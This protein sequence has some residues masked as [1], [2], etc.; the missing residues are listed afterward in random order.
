MM[1]AG[2][3]IK[4]N[5]IIFTKQTVHL[6]ARNN[7]LVNLQKHFIH[8]LWNGSWK[9]EKQQRNVI[10]I[11]LIFPSRWYIYG[12][13]CCCSLTHT[14]NSI[15]EHEEWG[16]GGRFFGRLRSDVKQ[17]IKWLFNVIL[18]ECQGN[19]CFLFLAPSAPGKTIG[20]WTNLSTRQAMNRSQ[21]K[22]SMNFPIMHLSERKTYTKG[23]WIGGEQENKKKCRGEECKA[24]TTQHHHYTHHITKRKIPFSFD[25]E[26]RCKSFC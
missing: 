18:D 22:S 7:L 15:L 3:R 19:S 21:N 16:G 20:S 9:P 24:A 12:L 2:H 4:K 14:W 6:R 10:I 25:P 1:R 23:T 17:N 5:C 8:F 26:T 13:C 11:S